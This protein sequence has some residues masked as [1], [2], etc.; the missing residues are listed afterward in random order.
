MDN[1]STKGVDFLQKHIG[2]AIAGAAAGTVC[3]L[4]GAGGGMVLVPLLGLLTD[5]PRERIFFVSVMIML[6][7]AA[8]SLLIS[9]FIWNPEFIPFLMGSTLG[10]LLA[11]KYG[12]R[13]PSALLHKG[14]G[15]LILW[16]GVRYLW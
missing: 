10:G 2:I 9:G 12:E 13:I 6:P 5:L 3:G 4:L 14:L 1:I 16:A 15:I 8:T 7:I 11:G